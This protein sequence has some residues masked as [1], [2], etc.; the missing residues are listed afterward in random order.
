MDLSW[1]YKLNGDQRSNTVVYVKKV[2]EKDK[3][4]KVKIK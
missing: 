1:E 3:G 2:E 4:T